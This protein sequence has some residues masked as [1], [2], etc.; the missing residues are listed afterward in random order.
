MTLAEVRAQYPQYND[1][2]DEQLGQ[3]L[4][5]KFYADMPYEQ[6]SQKVGI[7][8]EKTGESAGSAALISAGRTGDKINKGIQEAK[9][10]AGYGVYHALGRLGVPGMEQASME[11]ADQLQSMSA[12][13]ADEDARFGKLEKEFPKSTFV[14]GAAPYLGMLPVSA[15]PAVAAS[16]SA[17]ESGS[18][19]ERLA[20]VGLTFAG[21]KA[22]EAVGTLA[23]R[24][25]KP[26]RELSQAQFEANE[27]ADRLGVKL[28]AGEASGNR[29]LKFAESATADMPL[30]AGMAT[31]RTTANEQAMNRA[32]LKQLGQD[33]TEITE[34]A[35]AQ[36]RNDTS[37][38]YDSILSRAKIEL[39]NSFR[40]EVKV[41]TGSQVMKELRDESTDALI[42]KFTNMPPGKISVSGEWFQQ[43]K[44]AL[45]QAIRSAYS[46]N[47]AGKAQALEKFEDALN[48]AAMRS[49]SAEDRA[50]YQQA[51]KQWATLRILETGKVVDNGRIM[52]GRLDQA[53]ASRYKGAYKEGKIQGELSDIARLANTLRPPPNSGSVP[54]AI[55]SGGIGGMLMAEPMTAAGMLA[56]PVAA[57]SLLTSPA[58]RRYMTRGLM[59]LS[60]EAEM[61]L[62]MGGGALGRAP[63]LQLAP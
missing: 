28:S 50:L 58:M 55:Y 25:I 24:A 17:I 35:L 4:H 31:K 60:D 49:L 2:S 51:N 34:S 23:A 41:I 12:Q 8:P 39:D 13:S 36:G 54:R 11:N 30:A 27:A 47:Q 56:G 43:N 38:I 9:L 7:A 44:T 26:T 62:L 20:R 63:A 45:D 32:A 40:S 10:A 5:A 57:Q 1:L 52:P 16:L 42:S 33:G 19:G 18:P 46:N 6:F 53:L 48:R 22:G 21:G 37:A 3:A 59:G 61:A 15:G 14:G 29:A